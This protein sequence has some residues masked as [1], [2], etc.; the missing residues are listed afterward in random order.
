MLALKNSYFA[1]ARY[2]TW[3]GLVDPSAQLQLIVANPARYGQVLLRTLF[4]TP[5]V[6]LA[7]LGLLRPIYEEPFWVYPILAVALTATLIT[8]RSP[9]RAFSKHLKVGAIALFATTAGIVSTLLYLQWT[10]VGDGVIQGFQGRYLLP[11]LP[12][13]LMFMPSGGAERLVLRS[14]GWLSILGVVSIAATCWSTWVALL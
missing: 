2:F 10:R 11:V 6:P 7:V 12:L 5:T 1:G 4:A 13:L 8:D 14:S 3:S 9:S